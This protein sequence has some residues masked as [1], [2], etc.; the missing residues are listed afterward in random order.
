MDA[1]CACAR[2][3]INSKDCDRILY[4]PVYLIIGLDW[5]ATSKRFLRNA[6]FYQ[7]GK[8]L[9]FAEIQPTEDAP[10]Q[11][12]EVEVSLNE[13]FSG[14]LPR[15]PIDERTFNAADE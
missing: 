13:V 6:E 9:E 10:G 11:Y 3:D 1:I 5:N 14:N 12:Q 7:A 2:A 15:E 8:K 4:A